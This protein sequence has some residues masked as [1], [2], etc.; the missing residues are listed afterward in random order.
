MCLLA[1]KYITGWIVI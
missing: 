1:V